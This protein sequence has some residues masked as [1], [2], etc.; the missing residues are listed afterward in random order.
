VT[1]RSKNP[2]GSAAI[3]GKPTL[4]L[5]KTLE[6]RTARARARRA[7]HTRGWPGNETVSQGGG[8]ED[9]RGKLCGSWARS[10]HDRGRLHPG[11]EALKR[12]AIVRWN[13]DAKPQEGMGRETGTDPGG[14]H[15][16]REESRERRRQ[17]DPSAGPVE[18]KPSSGT[19]P[20]DGWIRGARPEADQPSLERCGDDEP[21]ESHRR[22]TQSARRPTVQ[23]RKAS[24]R[25]GGMRTRRSDSEGR[26]DGP[27]TPS[28]GLE[29]GPEGSAERSR[30][31]FGSA[32]DRASKP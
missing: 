25:S 14:E 23:T 31:R 15:A 32:T 18:M 28:K 10:N 6:C 2:K 7:K 26:Q 30:R 20:G 3:R 29:R 11:K 19:N 22:R 27:G 9:P 4:P 5:R 8:G 17:Q 12:R 21:Q 13:V 16:S 24:P 1:E